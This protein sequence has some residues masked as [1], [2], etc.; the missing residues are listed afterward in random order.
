MHH[1][2]TART[3]AF[4]A[5]CCGP[6]V[7]LAVIHWDLLFTP[8]GDISRATR[9]P[10]VRERGLTHVLRVLTD[11]VRD[12][13]TMRLV[14]GHRGVAVYG[15]VGGG[16]PRGHLR[17]GRCAWWRRP[18]AVAYGPAGGPGAGGR[19]GRAPGATGG[20]RADRAR[21]AQLPCAPTSIE[22]M[23]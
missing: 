7:T 6:L 8:D 1:S 18:G 2:H 10:A 16:V 3:A 14:C 17:R 23:A 9:C 22:S 4:L 11:R 12:P 5:L 19:R 21:P 15:P 20:A 13:L